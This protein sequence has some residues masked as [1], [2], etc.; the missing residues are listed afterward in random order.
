MCSATSKT[1]AAGMDR[2]NHVAPSMSLRSSSAC[3]FRLGLPS[4][5]IPPKAVCRQAQHALDGIIR[6][7]PGDADVM[8]QEIQPRQVKPLV[9]ELG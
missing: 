1:T 2:P 4:S 6:V 9:S 3:L 8:V 7:H 5:W